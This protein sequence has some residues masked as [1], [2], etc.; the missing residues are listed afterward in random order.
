MSGARRRH[1]SLGLALRALVVAY[2]A[3]LI[4]VP[5]AALVFTGLEGGLAGVWRAISAPAARDALFLSLWTAL[6]ATLVNVVAGTATAWALVRVDFRGRRFVSALVDLPFAVPTLVAG[7][8]IVLLFAPSGRLGAALGARGIEI[9]FATPAIVLA[10]LFITLPFVVRAVE[11]VLRE[12]DP[13]EEEAALTLGATPWK[14]LR[15]VVLPALTPAITS[16]ALQGFSRC[17]AEFGSIVVVSGNIPFRTLAVPVY[18]FGQ[19][20]SGET[21]SAAAVSIALLA[22]SLALSFGARSLQRR[23]GIGHA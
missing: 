22:L 8:M 9:L 14:T 19:V 18:I 15:R 13:A 10:L 5:F 23:M 11:P 2:L 1:S 6:I 3:V 7:V 16:G 20:E 21:Q 12:L 17:L 4:I